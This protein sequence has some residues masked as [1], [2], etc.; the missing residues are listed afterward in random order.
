VQIPDSGCKHIVNLNVGILA[1][2]DSEAESGTPTQPRCN[3]AIRWIY[4]EP[5]SQWG[6]Y[7]KIN[8]FYSTAH[9]HFQPS[10]SVSVT[11]L[12]F[13]C[14]DCLVSHGHIVEIDPIAE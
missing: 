13:G 14:T 4:R 9:E 7:P 2:G 11:I 5:M 3:Q 10:R 1:I 6:D 8:A 12:I